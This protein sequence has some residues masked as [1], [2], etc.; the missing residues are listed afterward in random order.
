MHHLEETIRRR[1]YT[2]W[3]RAGRPEGRSEEFW[4]AAQAEI[5][6]EGAHSSEPFDPFEP[7]IDEPPVVAFQHGVPVGMPGER[8]AEQGV[9][10]DR[11]ADLIPVPRRRPDD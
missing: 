7:P 4:H 6:G 10:D 11:L 9:E 5:E 3:Q 1:A 8:I 2:L